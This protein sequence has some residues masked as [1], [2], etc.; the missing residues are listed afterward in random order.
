MYYEIFKNIYVYEA[1]PS[2]N[3]TT[4]IT[5]NNRVYQPSSYSKRQPPRMALG[6]LTRF[7]AS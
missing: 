4:Q 7:C 1:V 5:N 6:W 2:I 3:L